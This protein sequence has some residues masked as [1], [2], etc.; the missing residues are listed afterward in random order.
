MLLKKKEVSCACQPTDLSLHLFILYCPISMCR[1]HCSCWCIAIC[2]RTYQKQRL[3]NPTS[4][5][6]NTKVSSRDSCLLSWKIEVFW[7]SA[8]WQHR[9]NLKAPWKLLDL[10]S[11]NW[12]TSLHGSMFSCLRLFFL[13]CQPVV[14]IPRATLIPLGTG[15]WAPY[16]GNCRRTTVQHNATAMPTANCQQLRLPTT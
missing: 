6:T 8:R 7:C 13:K 11:E 12:F 9:D 10:L 1:L 14:P 4:N 3:F 2:V 16:W 5:A 15:L